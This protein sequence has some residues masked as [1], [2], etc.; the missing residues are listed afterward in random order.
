MIIISNVIWSGLPECPKR[1]GGRPGGYF[2]VGYWGSLVRG[3]LGWIPRAVLGGILGVVPRGWVMD[4]SPGGILGRNP[5][6]DKGMSRRCGGPAVGWSGEGG[7]G[8][9]LGRVFWG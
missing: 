2:W 8:R 9:G 6:G 3:S 1:H 7:G 4:I 5:E